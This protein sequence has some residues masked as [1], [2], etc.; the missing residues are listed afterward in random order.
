MILLIKGADMKTN[1]QKNI[2][3]SFLSSATILSLTK[4]AYTQTNELN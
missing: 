1:Q 2:A 4:D 3:R